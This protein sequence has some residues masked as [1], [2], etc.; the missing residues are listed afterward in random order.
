[1]QLPDMTE[2]TGM[3]HRG[4]FHGNGVYNIRST[5]MVYS[6]DWKYGKKHGKCINA[7]I[8]VSIFNDFEHSH[9]DFHV[10]RVGNM[11]EN[12]AVY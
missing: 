5:N 11:R 9:F 3:F 6:G 2:Y 7:N 8:F 4:Y 12:V 1:M 10:F